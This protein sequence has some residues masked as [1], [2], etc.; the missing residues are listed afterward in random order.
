MTLQFQHVWVLFLLWVVPAVGILWH[1]AAKRR[2]Y[3][4]NAFIS[5]VMAARLAPP[6]APARSHWQRILFLAGLLL[7]L[8]A[9]ARPQWGFRSENVYQ[10]GR[11]LLIVLDVS[12]SM[13]A[14]DVHPSRL[15]RAKVD[16]LDLIKQVRGDRVG[17]IAFR[18]RPILLCPLTTDYGF[19]AQV[20]EGAGVHSAPAGETSIGDG[21]TEALKTFDS[22]SG[23]H[24][25]IVLVSDGE[26]L[27]GRIEDAIQKAREQ[28][29]AV[30]TIGFG[31]AE[32]SQ[33][34][35][36]PGKKTFISYQGAPVVSRLN[37]DL[38]SDLATRTG[39]AYVPV[40]QANVKLGDL[41][42]DHLSRI[43]ARDLEESIQRRYIERYQVFLAFSV[44]CF[45]AAA[46]LSRGQIAISIRKTSSRST[47]AALR[48]LNPQPS[49]M[50]ELA[51]L[52]LLLGVFPYPGLA[53]TN[54]SGSGATPA[55]ASDTTLPAGRRGA[56]HAQNLYIRGKYPDAAA[57]YQSAA[58]TGA[59]RDTYAFN[60]GCSFLKAGQH[61]QAANA[62]RSVSEGNRELAASAAYN[63]GYS[64]AQASPTSA[65]DVSPQVAEQQVHQLKQAGAALQRSLKLDPALN[66]ARRNLALVAGKLTEAETQA[67]IA[68]L[69]ARYGQTQ[70]DVLAFEMLQGQRILIS[71]I[72]AA[73][74]NTSPTVINDL[75]RLAVDQDQIA[76]LMIPLKGKLIQALSQSPRPAL[77]TNI[78]SAQQQQAQLNSF[79]ES[80][81]DQM[82]NSAEKLR[83]LD[84][85]AET[86]ASGVESAVYHL[87]KGLASYPGLLKEDLR[88]QTNTIDL[89][90]TPSCSTGTAGRMTAILKEQN[91]AG[92]LT[93]LFISRFEEQVPPEGLNAPQTHP[94]VTNVA[95]SAGGTNA[96]KQ[97]ITP[98]TRAKIL[99]LAKDAL[100]CQHNAS[101]A[102]PISVT[103]SITHQRDAYSL[104]KEIEALLPKQDQPQPQQ[105][106]QQ[107]QNEQQHQQQS[108][109][110]PQPLDAQQQPDIQPREERKGEM[111]SDDVK[112]LLEKARQREKEHEQEKR[113]R[114]S[115]MPLSPAERDW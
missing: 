93:E 28:G 105:D 26:D 23:T 100:T 11:D 65:P 5:P 45:F 112:R 19:L 27:A 61:E 88:R 82:D 12:R 31:S 7:A 30:F 6:P 46:F 41:Y 75:E 72:P 109:E 39:G 87:W 44:L 63:L 35:E 115:H 77:A 92:S 57:A 37:H 71:A 50:K 73:F 38:M 9:A 2:P 66:D 58:R 64:L 101:Q 113:E 25:A 17:L 111:S 104:L 69:M 43:D 95:A 98:E 97:L 103:T 85:S 53:S 18:G 108:Q 13:L 4:G 62:F 84:R 32:G 29:V 78:P 36:E 10:K 76:D 8:I 70:P 110:N 34:P 14:T 56:R 81:R 99:Q 91:E 48:D 16:L 96:V 22:D 68:R 67:R 51:V 54:P 52:I 89:S 21:V 49:L 107:Q 55:S 102:L 3:P 40:G 79:A 47:A 86:V 60:A 33:L 80:I 114:N 83:N 90:A 94:V 1:I 20:L 24:R 74:T 59:Y 42:R 106:P 15:G